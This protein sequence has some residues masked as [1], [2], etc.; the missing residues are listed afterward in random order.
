MQIRPEDH[1]LFDL[2]SCNRISN[3]SFSV[4][5]AGEIIILVMVTFG[6]GSSRI[7]AQKTIPKLSAYLSIL[8]AFAGG[9][10]CV[11]SIIS[12]PLDLGLY[13]VLCALPWFIFAQRPTRCLPGMNFWTV[14]FTRVY[15][16]LR[17]HATQANILF[18]IFSCERLRYLN[19]IRFNSEQ[20]RDVLYTTV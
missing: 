18:F 14:M 16:A 5:S 13:P 8:I 19:L 6:K 10:W 12:S 3:A 17:V 20:G 2:L 4:S 1:A 9:I 11:S 7:K 15:V